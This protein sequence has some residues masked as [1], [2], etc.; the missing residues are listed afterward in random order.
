MT[1]K[2]RKRPVCAPASISPVASSNGSLAIQA[3][4]V[5]GIDYGGTGHYI[6]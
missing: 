3:I 1:S 4:Q 6:S 2:L 5:F